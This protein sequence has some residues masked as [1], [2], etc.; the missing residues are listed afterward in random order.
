MEKRLNILVIDDEQIVLDS[1]NKLLRK[2][3]YEVIGVLSAQEGLDRLEKGDIDIVLTDLMMPG[4]DGL[5]FM[6]IAKEKFPDLPIIMIT[7]YATI[8]T[9]LQATQLGAFDYVAKPFSKAE[10]RG[11]IKRAADIVGAAR[12]VGD[13]SEDMA[14]V[15]ADS[16]KSFM[17][18]GDK[19]WMVLQED[20]KVLLGVK[21]SFL[22]AVGKIQ[23][24][25]LPTRGEK[26]RQ[27]SVCVQFFSSDMRAHTCVTPLSGTVVDT[28]EKISD[29]PDLLLEDPYGEGWLVKLEPSNYE[30]EIKT[31]GL[32]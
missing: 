10:F 3:N 26:L 32:G 27:G 30:Y 14:R 16:E 6:K 23:N 25:F 19:S 1:I 5:E 11:V 29:N 28:N 7:G 22:H 12:Q 2:D 17:T 15:A 8:N 4:I 13:D 31:L 9:A 24:I 20:G 18:I 21:R